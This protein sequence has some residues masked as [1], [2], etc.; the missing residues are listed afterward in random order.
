M[1]DIAANDSY[2]EILQSYTR[3]E[4]WTFLFRFPYEYHRKRTLISMP[5]SGFSSPGKQSAVFSGLAGILFMW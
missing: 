3:R 5:E 4:R 2:V 1:E